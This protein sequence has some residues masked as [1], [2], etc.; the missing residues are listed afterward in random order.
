MCSC[1]EQGLAGRDACCDACC[2]PFTHRPGGSTISVTQTSPSV[3]AMSRAASTDHSPN[4]GPLPATCEDKMPEPGARTQHG[5]RQ[6]G[7]AVVK[8]WNPSR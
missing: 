6:R 4:S 3:H 5:S 8:I 7:C 2:D 1:E